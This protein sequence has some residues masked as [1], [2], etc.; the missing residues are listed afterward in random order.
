MKMQKNNVIYF[1]DKIQEELFGILDEI[2]NFAVHRFNH[3]ITEKTE[4]LIKDINV[5]DELSERIFPQLVW[6]VIF[7]SP[8]AQD[9]PSI[10]QQFLHKNKH[11]WQEK[12]LA[13]Q[14]IL[15]SWL[16]LNPGFHYVEDT[17][18][19][20]GRVFI[21]RDIFEDEIKIVGI[22][23][24]TFQAPQEGELIIGLLLPMGKGIYTTQGGL[25]HIPEPYTQKIV[26]EVIPYYQ[27]HSI[28]PNYHLNPQLFPSMIKLAL[29][30]VERRMPN[31]S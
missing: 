16:S 24:K 5:S 6:W 4:E 11:R 31:G 28:S 15:V 9:K 13:I 29:E 8:S 25:F 1:P 10:Y 3:T 14:E 12:S 7:C 30:K 20:S 22:Y 26:R 2:F 17:N 23:N 27:K 19:E 21:F 18:S